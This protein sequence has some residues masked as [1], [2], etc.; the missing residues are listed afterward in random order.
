MTKRKR[1]KPVEKSKKKR[2]KTS[3]AKAKGRN[4]QQWVAQQISDITG[5]P[6][7]KDE[8]ISSREMGQ[9]GTD[10]R[11]IGEAKDKFPFSV[12]CK[13]QEAWS[14]HSWIDQA[15][16][17]ETEDMPWL[18]IAKRSR[19]QPIVILDAKLFF[20]LMYLLIRGGLS[21]SSLLKTFRRTKKQK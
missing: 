7:G 12:E 15:I 3:S 6:F 5:I 11:L 13:A 9:S 21:R 2:I 19:K 8:C 18:L 1:T 10:I 20:H 17:N 14:V 16:S 4:L